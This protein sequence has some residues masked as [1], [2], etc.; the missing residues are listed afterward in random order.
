MTKGKEEGAYFTSAEIKALAGE[1]L[2]A[3]RRGLPKSFGEL[4]MPQ[5][6]AKA[7]H[8]WRGRDNDPRSIALDWTIEAYVG[9]ELVAT[10]PRFL[11]MHE[12]LTA[13]GYTRDKPLQFAG[14]AYVYAVADRV[15]DNP[16]DVELH[17]VLSTLAGWKPTTPGQ[18]TVK[19]F[20]VQIPN[21][22]FLFVLNQTSTGWTVHVR[23]I[24]PALTHATPEV[25]WLSAAI[26]TAGALS[27]PEMTRYLQLLERHANDVAG[28]ESPTRMSL[29]THLAGN[30][31]A[32]D[33]SAGQGL[34]HGDE[35]DAGY[36]ASLS[37][38][39]DGPQAIAVGRKGHADICQVLYSFACAYRK[40]AG[41]T[42][43]DME[44]T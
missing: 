41:T 44:A 11:K 17:K 34:C 1:V 13:R 32:G 37:V 16:H 10:M 23:R 12:K 22:N 20:V 7:F 19:A 15:V 39:V 2:K 26:E 25:K 14:D 9:Q 42:A 29:E 28:N 18:I 4:A 43:S 35:R 21:M 24:Y 6:F 30:L 8:A 31:I 36:V 33:L 5:V 27:L 38:T 3:L 40:L